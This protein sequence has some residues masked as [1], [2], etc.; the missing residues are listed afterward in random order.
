MSLLLCLLA[1][2]I[3]PCL[4][5]WSYHTFRLDWEI[6][7]CEQLRDQ[8]ERDPRVM[9]ES[10]DVRRHFCRHPGRPATVELNGKRAAIHFYRGDL[11]V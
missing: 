11:N 3:T 5:V 9:T 7:Q 8:R 6:Y 10:A 4:L 2:F 1:G